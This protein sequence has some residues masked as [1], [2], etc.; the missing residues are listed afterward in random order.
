MNQTKK[1]LSIINFAISI[2]D[3]ETIQLQV[4]KLGLLKTDEKIQN[5]ITMIQAEN[6]AQAQGLITAYMEAPTE[7][8]LQRSSQKEKHILTKDEQS[9]IDEFKLFVTPNENEEK[10]EIN[11]NDFMSDDL[12]IPGDSLEQ[13]KK[14]RE[15]VEKIEEINLN[16]FLTISQVAPDKQVE[17]SQ[18]ETN[19]FD[20]LLNI[21]ADDVLPDNIDLNIDYEEEDNF[22][23]HQDHKTKTDNYTFESP[24]DNF[25]DVHNEEIL[26]NEKKTVA[27]FNHNINV[28]KSDI[29]IEEI[30]LGRNCQS[31]RRCPI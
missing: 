11:I 16:D 19:D 9:T 14:S 29:E 1:R 12:H 3:I 28:E 13:Q 31:D 27:D 6:Y 20:S 18:I 22:F 17:T 7:N 10:V 26:E 30:L 23:V 15:N 21:D 2:T 24:K 25:F 4:L 5:I 8:V